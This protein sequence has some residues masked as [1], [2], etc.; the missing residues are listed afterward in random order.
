MSRREY[1]A[2]VAPRRALG[3][4]FGEFSGNPMFPLQ[5]EAVKMTV[6]LRSIRY[7][8]L[9]AALLLAAHSNL[10]R[11]DLLDPVTSLLSGG[12]EKYKTEIIINDLVLLGGGG[13]REGGGEGGGYSGR[14]GAGKSSASGG[15]DQRTSEPDVSQAPASGGG[16][17]ITDEDIP[18]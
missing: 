11:A 16:P 17:E 15:F 7:C 1:V 4:G 10:A 8:A 6:L 5:R 2:E 14:S 3:Y 18:F 9:P 13:P 12:G